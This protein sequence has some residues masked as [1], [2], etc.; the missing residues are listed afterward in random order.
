MVRVLVSSLSP[1][2]G[3]SLCALGILANIVDMGNVKV[4]VLDLDQPHRLHKYLKL[5]NVVFKDHIVSYVPQVD[6]RSCDSCGLCEQICRFNAIRLRRM[7][8]KVM[9]PL[10]TGCGVCETICPRGAIVMKPIPIGSVKAYQVD[11]QVVVG[12]VDNK[13]AVYTLEKLYLASMTMLGKLKPD[14]TIARGPSGTIPKAFIR[15]FEIGILVV[16][17]SKDPLATVRRRIGIMKRSGTEVYVVLN[18]RSKV[19]ENRARNLMR[20]LRGKVWS[21]DM[22]EDVKEPVHVDFEKRLGLVLSKEIMRAT[23]H[24]A[25]RIMEVVRA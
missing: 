19:T 13:T 7:G 16:D 22:M 23:R 14:I 1:L 4:L 11:E 10:C 15:G 9:M 25:E 2:S 18:R 17:L 5:S 20:Y 12:F 3:R 21:V 24:I 6:L 8:P